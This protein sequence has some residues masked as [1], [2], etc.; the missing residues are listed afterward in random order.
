MDFSPKRVSQ[1]M[2]SSKKEDFFEEGN[3]IV[4][5]YDFEHNKELLVRQK[6]K[7]LNMHYNDEKF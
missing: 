1:I 7:E 6:L 5:L 3:L 2:I 4:K